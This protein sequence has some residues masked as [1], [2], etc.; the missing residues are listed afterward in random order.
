MQNSAKKQKCLN[1]KPKITY[2]GTLLG[3]VLENYCHNLNQDLQ[4][5]LIVKSDKETNMM[6]FG[7][8]NA[9]FGYFWPNMLYLDIFGLEF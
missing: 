2:L 8:S 1:L 9:L 7:T 4:I 5:C 3:R 6:K